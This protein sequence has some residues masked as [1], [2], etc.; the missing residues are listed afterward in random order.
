MAMSPSPQLSPA[1]GGSHLVERQLSNSPPLQQQQQVSKRDKRR[2]ALAHR[3]EEITNQFSSNRDQNYR[4]QLQA[5]QLDMNLIMEADPHSKEFLPN[6]RDAIDNL[7]KA[8]FTKATM[9][10]VGPNAPSRAGKMY[11]DFAKEINDAM[12]ERDTHLT[13]HEV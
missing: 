13:S 10:Q 9:K 12:E 8:H 1:M 11:A 2:T 7:I 3:L 4:N 6:D 5:L